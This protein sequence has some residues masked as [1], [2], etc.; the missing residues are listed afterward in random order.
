MVAPSATSENSPAKQTAV[1]R[2]KCIP[3]QVT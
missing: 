1:M 2:K 3:N